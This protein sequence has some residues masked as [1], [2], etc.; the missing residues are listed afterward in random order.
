MMLDAEVAALL[1]ALDS[2]FPQVD[3]M[4]GSQARAAIRARFRPPAEPTP[5]RRVTERRIPGPAGPIRLRIYWPTVI[6]IEPL[7]IVVFAHGGGFVFCDLDTHDDLCRRMANGI[8]AVI[9]S[10]DYRL[11]PEQPWPAAPEDVYTAASW[12]ADHAAE[13]GGDP[14][15]LAVAGDSAGGNLA[16]VTALLARDRGGPNLSAQLLLY[17]VLAA[18]FETKSYRDFASGFYNTRSAMR[19]YWDQYIPDTRDREQHTA[20][21]L[22]AQLSGLP[23]AVFVTAEY[24]PLATEGAVY[25][26]AL[27]ASG[28]SVIHRSYAAVHGF[29]SINAL[30]IARRA[31]ERAWT[32]LDA[33]LR[34]KIIQSSSGCSA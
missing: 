16:T 24:D 4:T 17:P 29:M 1:P 14:T 25:V 13:I 12:A 21:P 31:Q 33:L 11:A 15:R 26:N 19:W 22:R 18:D 10:V 5:V 20:S 23:P 6:S 32:D 27:R 34:P 28:V 8:G 9:V 2:G 3:I 7:P 30:T